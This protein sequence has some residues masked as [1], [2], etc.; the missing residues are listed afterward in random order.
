MLHVVTQ[1]EYKKKCC[2]IQENP[3]VQHSRKPAC[4]SPASPCLRC[5]AKSGEKFCF[6]RKHVL[7]L[8]GFP[9]YHVWNL[10]ECVV[11][12]SLNCKRWNIFSREKNLCTNLAQFECWKFIIFQKKRKQ[13]CGLHRSIYSPFVQTDSLNETNTSCFL[14]PCKMLNCIDSSKDVAQ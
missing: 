3:K 8:F 13:L 6:Q 5:F 2:H 14:S 7:N 1:K 9:I 4:K 11:H 12:Y 10:R